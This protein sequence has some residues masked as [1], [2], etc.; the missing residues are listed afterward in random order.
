MNNEE[1][2]TSCK[3]ND[4][5]GMTVEDSIKE[6]KR[7]LEWMLNEA[8]WDGCTSIYK[9]VLKERDLLESLIKE[10]TEK[11]VN[12]REL[13]CRYMEIQNLLSLLPMKYDGK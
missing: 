5:A 4:V 3:H 1:I 9:A 11:K 10:A 12:K 2:I 7:A 8:R 6:D 13:N